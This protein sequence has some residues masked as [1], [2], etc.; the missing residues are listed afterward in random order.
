MTRSSDKVVRIC[1]VAP[2][3]YPLFNRQCKEIF[4]GAELDLFMLANE[5][6]KDARFS[7][8]FVVADY[9]QPPDET[10]NGISTIASL[11]FSHGFVRGASRIWKALKQA[12]ADIYV[13]KTASAGVPLLARFC[14]RHK[15]RFVYRTA[16]RDECDG[17]YLRRHPLLGRLFINALRRADVVFAQNA[18]DAE[19]LRR[20]RGIDSTVIPNG[21][22]LTAAD[23]PPDKDTILWVG[24]SAD[25]KQPQIFLDVARHL[26]DVR[27]VMICPK[28]TDDRDYES[29][30]ADAAG[31]A[32]LEFVGRVPFDEID[33]YFRRAKVLVNTSRAEGFANTFIQACKNSA[34]I[35]SLN[36][37]PDDFLVRYACGIACNG[38]TQK[39][40]EGLQFLLD[41]DRYREIGENG[42]RYVRDNHDIVKIAARYKDIFLDLYST[43]TAR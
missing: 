7:I 33:S 17:T 26:P 24:R 20:L 12:D 27:F 10:Y 30:V 43:S 28:A 29:L 1:F 36:S 40:I 39:L 19:D 9:G 37:N 6:V 34:A 25:F 14:R 4:G 42:G 38:D 23:N 31:I 21:H 15:R 32:N 41:D 2:K 22:C 13:I 18:C 5:L 3:A 8:S 11:D 35:L 16:H